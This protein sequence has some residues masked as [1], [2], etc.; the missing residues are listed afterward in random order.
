MGPRDQILA[1]E[2]EDFQAD[3]TIN[4]QLKIAAT[5]LKNP[6]IQKKVLTGHRPPQC[7]H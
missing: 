3:Q 6:S 2:Y 7:H 5:E 4:E 1:Q